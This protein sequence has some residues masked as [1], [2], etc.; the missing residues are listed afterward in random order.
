MI[1]HPTGPIQKPKIAFIGDAPSREDTSRGTPLS[2]SA[3]H[4]FDEILRKVGIVREQCYIT[5]VVHEKPPGGD[6]RRMYYFDKQGKKPNEKLLECR[7]RLHQE[8]RDISPQVIIPL[9][10]EALRAIALVHGLSDYR[11]TPID[12]QMKYETRQILPTY[13]PSHVLQVY[14]T[15]PIMELDLAKALRFSIEGFP[16]PWINFNTKPQLEEILQFC[17]NPPPRIA[18]DIETTISVPTVTRCIGFAWSESEALSIPL[19]EYGTHVWSPS[20]ERLIFQNLKPLLA[21]P[22]VKKI[23]HNGP[24][25]TTVLE[26]EFRHYVRSPYALRR[27]PKR[28]RLPQFNL[29]RLPHVLGKR[30]ALQRQGQATLQLLRLLCH[31]QSR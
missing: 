16:N 31:I 2:G 28:F 17:Q 19:V 29:H 18:C 1:V 30:Q 6:F 23:F 27:I 5:N 21:D 12:K 22:Q 8:I 9:G 24:F 25:D 3:G 10:E 26:R 14:K 11:G 15:R 13:H 20:E 7:K 4:L